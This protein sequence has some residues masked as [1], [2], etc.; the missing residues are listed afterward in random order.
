MNLSPPIPGEARKIRV[1][2]IITRLILGGAQENTLLSCIGLRGRPEYDVVLVTGPAPGREG[3]LFAEARR[4]NVPVHLVPELQ[5]E[6]HLLRD[7]IAFIRL[8]LFLRRWRPRIVHT[9]SSKAGVLGRLAARLA[10]V[11]FILHTIHGLPFHDYQSPLR[12]AVYRTMEQLAS[13]FCD[14]VAAV[15]EVMRE[16]AIRARLARR[17]DV[18]YSGIDL[19]RFEEIPRAEAR[20]KLGL[21]EELPIAAIVSRLAPL[22]GH[23]DLF[24]AAERIRNEVPGLLLLLVGDG[25]LRERLEREAGRRGLAVHFAG[26]VPPDRIVEFLSAA[27]IVVHPSYREGLP[28]VV[29]QALS[30]RRPVIAYDCDG[31]RECLL[32]GVTGRLIAPGD[33]VALA[34]AIRELLARPDRG[35]AWAEEGRRRF[36]SRFDAGRMIQ[37]LHEIYHTRSTA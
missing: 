19:S 32:D 27:D 16:K 13:L 24:D 1:A 7:L 36:L 6:I 37:A 11:P 18:I 26:L 2:H 21:P 35:R 25:E 17:V 9:H 8:W 14:R 30:C 29:P 10:G 4:R 33:R 20:R 5:R 23:E 12:R 22:K 15:G 3:D 28:R 31:A 34:A